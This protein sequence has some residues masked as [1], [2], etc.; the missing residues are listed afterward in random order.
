MHSESLWSAEDPRDL[1][2]PLLRDLNEEQRQAVTLP[3]EHALILAGA[4]LGK[5]RMLTTRI[6]WRIQSR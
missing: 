1:S 5:T 3:A 2:S 6:A 4:W